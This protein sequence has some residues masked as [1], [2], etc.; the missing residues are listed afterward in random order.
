VSSYGLDE[1]DRDEC[2]DLLRRATIGRVA[3]TTGERPAIL[4]VLF[5][6]L[7]GDVII[8]TA[9][10]DK[11]VAALLHHTVPFEVDDHDTERR[12]G[13]SVLVVG[14]AEEIVR[15]DEIARC[16]AL[17]LESWAGDA[18][19]RWV[20]IRAENVTGRRTAARP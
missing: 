6:V 1:L 4:P 9:P 7:D 15:P 2:L 3:I 8:R 19:D 20:R 16:E 12:A 18:R 11:L 5:A 17:G 13:W 14:R 10:G